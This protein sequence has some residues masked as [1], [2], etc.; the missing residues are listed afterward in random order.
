MYCM[1]CNHQLG[2]HPDYKCPECGWPFNPDDRD[3]FVTTLR[4]PAIAVSIEILLGV[5]QIF[6]LG[7][8][9]AGCKH[10]GLIFMFGYWALLVLLAILR[11]VSGVSAVAFPIA[12]L[13]TLVLSAFL[14]ARAALLPETEKT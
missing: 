7:H 1:N 14:A 8:F 10:N 12:W 6:G 2:F 3:S 5:F 4:S 11:P 9:Y 13:L